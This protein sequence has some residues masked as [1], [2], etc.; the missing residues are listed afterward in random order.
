MTEQPRRITVFVGQIL[1]G[2]QVWPML[3]TPTS[4]A[5]TGPTIGPLRILTSGPVQK[6]AKFEAAFDITD[7]A[8][9]NPYYPYDA[10]LSAGIQAGISASSPTSPASNGPLHTWEYPLSASTTHPTVAEQVR[11]STSGPLAFCA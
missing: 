8:A 1:V 7:T 10:A 4:A 11:A 6:C 3:A 9:T 2:I 5:M